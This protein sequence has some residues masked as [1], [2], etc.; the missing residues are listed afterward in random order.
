LK[1]FLQRLNL[2]A[3]SNRLKQVGF[4]LGMGL[5]L[6]ALSLS[7][8]AQAAEL[9]AIKKRGY[10]IVG[11]KDNLRPLGFRNQDQLQGFEIE[12]ARQLA[13]DLLGDETAVEFRP[14]L[15]QDRLQA[16]L[17]GEVDI[18]VARMTITA[19]RQRLIDFSRPYFIDGTAF[20]AQA[21]VENLR[22][23]NGQPVAVLAGSDTIASVRSLLP[24]IRLRGVDSYEEARALLASGEVVAVAADGAVLTGWSQE[25]PQYRLLPTLISA[26][27]LAVAVP[28]GRQY[29]ELRQQIDA[30][31]ER[32]L[33]NGWLRRQIRTW[34][35]PAE[36]FPSLPAEAAPNP[37][38]PARPQ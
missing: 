21:G 14:L 23:L 34:G 12:I 15:N 22:D 18:L 9:S 37:A 29:S 25:E 32:W 11:V 7:Q 10:L 33:A 30:A 31:V 4:L 5:L 13:R 16:L 6:A 24:Q 35:L 19:S 8:L 20:L 2:L 26:E 1:D 3:E 38:E 36:G 17:N 28:R 27:A